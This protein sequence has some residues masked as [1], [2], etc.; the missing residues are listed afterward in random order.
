MTINFISMTDKKMLSADIG[1]ILY[2]KLNWLHISCFLSKNIFKIIK[3]PFAIHA[4]LTL[5]WC[6]YK[7][8][9]NIKPMILCIFKEFKKND[10]LDIQFILNYKFLSLHILLLLIV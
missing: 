1:N 2:I 6:I 4:N 9:E 8:Y 10:A 5:Q 7:N 3:I